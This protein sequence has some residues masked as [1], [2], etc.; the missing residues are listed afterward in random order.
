MIEAEN[1]SGSPGSHYG[2]NWRPATTLKD[3]VRNCEAGLE[4]YSDRRMAK[5]MGVSRV[6][7]Y[8]YQLMAEIPE[9]EWDALLAQDVRWSTKALANVG[10]AMSTDDPLVKV[11]I[12]HCPH[13]GG[14]VR[15]RRHIG[16]KA[17]EAIRA[18]NAAGADRA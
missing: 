15:E 8:R 12:E 6:Q 9:V 16:P 1:D 4:K 2:R 13:C 10:L 17:L 14:V 3:Y 11:D 18:V 7:L 5:L